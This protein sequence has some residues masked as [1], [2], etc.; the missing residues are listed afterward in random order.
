MCGGSFKIFGKLEAESHVKS[1]HCSTVHELGGQHRSQAACN[2]TSPA[3][4]ESD[5]FWLPM[6]LPTRAHTSPRCI[7]VHTI[8]RKLNPSSFSITVKLRLTDVL[9]PFLSRGLDLLHTAPH[10]V[11]G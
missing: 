1:T 4:G 8:K 2:H 5:F 9:L 11:H 10:N 6:H 3:P 7:D